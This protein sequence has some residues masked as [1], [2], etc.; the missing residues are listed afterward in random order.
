MKDNI[1]FK[2][3]YNIETGSNIFQEISEYEQPEYVKN[4]EG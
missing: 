3:C 2:Y 4:S 1:K